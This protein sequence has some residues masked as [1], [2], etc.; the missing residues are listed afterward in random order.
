ML[1]AC[2][3]KD[4]ELTIAIGGFDGNLHFILFK[5]GELTIL[6]TYDLIQFSNYSHDEITELSFIIPHDMIVT[7]SEII[8]G[9]Q[10]GYYL[11]FDIVNGVKK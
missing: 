8:I 4:E 7:E 10:E 5:D 9:T 2:T 3:V 11:K 1:K 6:K